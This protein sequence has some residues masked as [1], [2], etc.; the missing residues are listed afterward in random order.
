M[1]AIWTLQETYNKGSIKVLDLYHMTSRK[2]EV[3]SLA[4]LVSEVNKLEF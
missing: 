2:R 3:F 4:Y 1:K